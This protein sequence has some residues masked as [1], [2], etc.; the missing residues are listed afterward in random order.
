[1]Y[2]VQYI[3]GFGFPRFLTPPIRV[4]QIYK[5]ATGNRDCVLLK[6]KM[7][8]S[9]YKQEM[10]PPGGYSPLDWAKKIPKKINGKCVM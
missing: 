8:A 9:K 3:S 10:P 5:W 6:V 1:M 7:S 4:F 2:T